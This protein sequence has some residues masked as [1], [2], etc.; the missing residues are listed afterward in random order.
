MNR[1]LGWFVAAHVFL[2]GNRRRTQWIVAGVAVLALP[3]TLLHHAG[4]ALLPLVIASVLLVVY[5]L[6]PASVWW[7]LLWAI[8]IAALFTLWLVAIGHRW[9][10]LLPIVLLTVFFC[11]MPRLWGRAGALTTRRSLWF[12]AGVGAGLL[13]LLIV[14]LPFAL[15]FKGAEVARGTRYAEHIAPQVWS[16]QLHHGGH[17]IY[18]D[19]LVVDL[20]ADEWY[21]GTKDDPEQLV[22]QSF[23]DGSLVRIEEIYN[24]WYVWHQNG[25]NVHYPTVTP[26]GD[27]Q[28]GRDERLSNGADYIAPDLPIGALL[29]QF[30]EEVQYEERD[31]D[32]VP[33]VKGS[34]KP[35]LVGRGPRFFR[36][37]GNSTPFLLLNSRWDVT[38]FRGRHGK[39]FIRV[40]AMS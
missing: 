40:T 35:F 5:T 17:I 3:L 23:P 2:S 10:A 33:H 31:G 9:I 39:L 27:D 7:R 8:I 6:P 32:F 18:D 26:D 38:Q 24:D 1:I 36:V 13:V 20:K 34:P 15:S 14:W 19:T 29:V 16:R 30:G 28:L 4:W 25:H 37:H 21:F 11:L 12:I 22:P